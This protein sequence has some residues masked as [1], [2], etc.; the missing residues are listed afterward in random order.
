MHRSEIPCELRSF[1]IFCSFAMTYS[2]QDIFD[3][4]RVLVKVN[5]SKLNKLTWGPACWTM[6]HVSAASCEPS[7]AKAFCAFLYS[8]THVLPCPE[9]REHLR[10]YMQTHPPDSFIVDA[11]SASRFCYDLHNYVNGQSGKPLNPPQIMLEHYG[12]RLSEL[13]KP[14]DPTRSTRRMP[15][16]RAVRYRVLR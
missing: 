4:L 16:S 5:M 1:V 12:V 9:C 3:F 15:P 11:A 14:A 8:L 7:E 2:L 6:M 13:R 10:T